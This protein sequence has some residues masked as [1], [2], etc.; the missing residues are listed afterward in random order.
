LRRVL[1]D[2]N[3]VLDFVLDR[4]PHAAPAALLWAAAERNEIEAFLPAHGIT[5]VFYL[6]A[7]QHD[8]RFA[9]RVLE[10][11]LLV[12]G[13]AP[14]DGPILRRALALGWS[15]F[16]DAVSVAAAE[17]V[18]CDAIISRDPKGF[19]RSPV[20]VL[21]PRAALALLR[22]GPARA[23]ESAPPFAPPKRGPAL[24]KAPGPPNSGSR[25]R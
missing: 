1:F 19:P 9:R 15:D 17:G 24:R 20:R 8:Q 6:V 22:E 16:E 5:T 14:V 11:L 25:H 18:G 12:P 21:E 7:R 2:I 4:S 23:G 10:D 3:V 13:V